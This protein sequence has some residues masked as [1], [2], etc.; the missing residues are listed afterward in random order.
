MGIIDNEV[1]EREDGTVTAAS[2]V[3]ALIY[4]P[5]C[6]NTITCTFAILSYN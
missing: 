1:K 2:I 3:S 5:D 4:A 6:P